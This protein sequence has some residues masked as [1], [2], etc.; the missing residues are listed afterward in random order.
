MGEIPDVDKMFMNDKLTFSRLI[1]GVTFEITADIPDR[2]VTAWGS[3]F[4]CLFVMPD[5]DSI[6]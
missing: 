5:I 3:F 2:L 1:A 6:S 4:K